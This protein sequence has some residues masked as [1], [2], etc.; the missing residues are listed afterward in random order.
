MR[1]REAER[2]INKETET[3]RLESLSPDTV[4]WPRLNPVIRGNMK[5]VCTNLEQRRLCGDGLN[6]FLL[7]THIRGPKGHGM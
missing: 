4:N 1:T 5:K 2:G 6:G 7:L 3:E